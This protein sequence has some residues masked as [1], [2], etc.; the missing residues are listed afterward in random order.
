MKR[1]IL[2]VLLALVLTTSLSQ[3]YVFA[4]EYDVKEDTSIGDMEIDLSDNAKIMQRDNLI[5]EE[6][7]VESN[8]NRIAMYTADEIHV[9]NTEDDVTSSSELY[10]GSVSGYLSQTNDYVLYP[11]SVSAGNYLQAKLTLPNDAQIDY[12]LLLFDS[13]ISLIKSSDY[14]TCTSGERTLDE[15]VGY[16]ATSDEKIYICVYSVGNGSTT[17]PYTLDYSLTTNFSDSSEPNENAQESSQLNLTTSGVNVSGKINSPID[18]DWYS[19]TV[20]D[21]PEYNKVRL[22]VTSDSDINGCKIEI[23]RN[24]ISDYYAMLRIGSGNGGEISLP[25]GTYYLRIVSTNTFSDFNAAD[26]PTYNLSVAPISRVDDVAINYFEGYCGQIVYDYPEGN[27]YRIEETTPNVIAIHGR[28]TYTDDNG[29]KKG[30]ANVKIDGEVV[31]RQWKANNRPDMAYTDGTAITDSNGLFTMRVYLKSG[32]GG[33]RYNAP[34]S[35][36]HYDLMEANITAADNKNATDTDYF[37]LLKLS[38]MY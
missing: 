2:S 4:K 33:L 15:S 31:N 34:V 17:E 25:A 19:F 30:A 24:L 28:A 9:D 18:N 16:L 12:D 13:S 10:Y 23:Y 8:I 29:Y 22:N 32:L 26:M 37:Y 3:N 14:V 35:V 38:D 11:I 36:H 7:V 1:K 21:S 20:L 27:F 6:T 5:E